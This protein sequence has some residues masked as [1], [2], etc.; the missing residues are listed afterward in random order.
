MFFKEDSFMD[1]LNIMLSPRDGMDL[2]RLSPDFT[3]LKAMAN[4]LVP[5]NRTSG[6]V[7]IN[8]GRV[9]QS[10]IE[11]LPAMPSFTM[12]ERMYFL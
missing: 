11:L 7:M 4:S 1:M 2:P 12:S 5:S 3:N 9:S 10:S 8:P 6:L